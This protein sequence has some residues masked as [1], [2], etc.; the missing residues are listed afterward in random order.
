MATTTAIGQAT[1]G[2]LTNEDRTYYELAMLPR[3]VPSFSYLHHGQV[4]IHPPTTL[5]ENKG[6]AIDWRLLNSFT[7]VT[8]ALTEGVTPDSQAISITNSS[9]TVTEYG[10]YVRYTR[11]LAAMGI[12]KVAAEASDA[13]G[14][15]AGDSLDQIVRAVV[16]AGT[17]VQYASTAGS[18]GAITAAMTFTAAEALE[19]LATLKANNAR[20]PDGGMF[21]AIIHPYTEYDLYQDAT[22]QNILSYAKERGNGNP[23]MTGYIGD[24]LG[25]RFYCSSN[26][27]YGTDDGSGSVDVYKTLVIGKGAFGIG[28]LAAHMPSAVKEEDGL[29]NNN[30]YKKMRPLRLINK[31]FG[32]GGTSDPLEQRASIGWYTTF[33][34]VIL[35]QNFMVRVEHACSL[36]TNT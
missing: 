16:I 9:A 6:D 20:P 12:D 17:T 11:K 19:A 33:V 29:V 10:A 14:E 13:L 8:T 32:S 31:D 34:A 25:L 28:G 22:F 2:T 5:P 24:A 15:Q 23:W 3:A 1:L 7:A 26:A 18:T 4:G 30:T 36:G 35:L 27:S 21:P